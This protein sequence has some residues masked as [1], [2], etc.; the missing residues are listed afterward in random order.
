M[1]P[2][3]RRWLIVSAA[4]LLVSAGG[5][6]AGQISLVHWPQ[7]GW[8]TVSPRQ[9]D[10]GRQPYQLLSG[11]ITIRNESRRELNVLDLRDSCGCATFDPDAFRIDAGQSRDV[12]Y[13]INLVST[14]SIQ[15]RYQSKAFDVRISPVIEGRAVLS[16]PT[17]SWRLHGTFL[18]EQ[19]PES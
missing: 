11:Q 12:R 2:G 7:N 9:L 5:I 6:L 8:L 13:V 4:M 16:P 1:N 18:A 10:L 19:R 15:E 17:A 14:I 3:L